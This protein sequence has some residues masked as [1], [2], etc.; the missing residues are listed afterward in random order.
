MLFEVFEKLTS[1]CLSKFHEKPCYFLLII[2]IKMFET[3]VL[4]VLTY[5]FIANIPLAKFSWLCYITLYNA[6]SLKIPLHFVK[7][8]STQV[9]LVF[10]KAKA[11]LLKEKISKDKSHIFHAKSTFTLYVARRYVCFVLKQSVTV[12][13]L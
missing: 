11:F 4:V 8:H 10:F 6:N 12:I 13:L 2:Y 9:L 5:A 7:F 3:I 1:A